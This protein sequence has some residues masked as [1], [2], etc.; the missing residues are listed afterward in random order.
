MTRIVYKEQGGFVGLS[1][2]AEI[3][4]DA[5]P[6]A[7]RERLRTLL[8]EAARRDGATRIHRLTLRIGR[9]VGVEPEALALAFEVATAGTA[10]E[11]ATL[12]VEP[13][14]V[15]CHCAPC[16]RDFLSDGCIY[17]C[18]ECGQPSGDVRQGRELELSSLEVS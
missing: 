9:L 10:A 4:L 13:V 15:V 17:L 11:G 14:E 16:G 1:R 7:S 12:E 8:L 3:P 18:S 2:G 6:D 5:L